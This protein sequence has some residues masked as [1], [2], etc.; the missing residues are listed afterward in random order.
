VKLINTLDKVQKDA[1]YSY[2]DLCDIN[3][4]EIQHLDDFLA[5]A[6]FNFILFDCLD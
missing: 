5:D 6:G 4:N 1:F 2:F 3:L